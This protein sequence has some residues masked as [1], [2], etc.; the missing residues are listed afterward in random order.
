MSESSRPRVAHLATILSVA[1]LGACATQSSQLAYLEP[2]QSSLS[3]DPNLHPLR[4]EYVDGRSVT[5]E[6]VGVEPG[7]RILRAVSL[8]PS[9]FRQPPRQDVALTVE[10]CKTYELAA[11]HSSAQSPAWELEI[12]RIRDEGYCDDAASGD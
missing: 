4:I 12:I 2:R 10:A 6:R 11:R 5:R 8:Q 1:L 7:T 9:R 3:T